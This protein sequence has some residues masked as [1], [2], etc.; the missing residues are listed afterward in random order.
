MS[1]AWRSLL[2]RLIETAERRDAAPSLVSPTETLSY[3]Q[4][5]D[6]ALEL[7]ARLAPARGELVA[8]ALP[9][10][11]GLVTAWLACW[12]AGAAFSTLDPSLPEARARDILR[13]LAPRFVL[14]ASG[15]AKCGAHAGEELWIDTAASASNPVEGVWS[16]ARALPM[17][18]PDALA[19]VC[20]TSGST[21][22]PKGAT[23]EH[24][25]LPHVIGDQVRAFE[26]DESAR[27]L[28]LLRPGFDASL[29]DV[30]TCLLAGGELHLAPGLDAGFTTE[31]LLESLKG[32]QITHVDLP[33][34]LLPRIPVEKLPESLR[35]VVVGGEAPDPTA[36]SD[37]AR[38]VRLLNV[39][40]P[41]ECSIC[42]SLLAWE[43][44]FARPYIGE[45]LSAV[46][47]RIGPADAARGEL[48]I[49]GAQLMRGY[50]EAPE[51][52][53][54]RFTELNGVRWYRTG[55]LVERTRRGPVFLGRTD[56]QLKLRGQLIAPEEVEA[57]L[58]GSG[59]CERAHVT[60]HGERLVALIQGDAKQESRL[61][62]TLRERLP[63]WMHPAR[64]VFYRHLPETASGK[65]DGA[66]LL[67]A[68]DAE[69]AT[70]ASDAP[71]TLLEVVA[72]RLGRADPQLSYF[73]QGGDSL[74]VLEVLCE[75]EAL[76]LEIT[77]EALAS[78][79][80]LGDL[81][82]AGE[83]ATTTP[84]DALDRD[85]RACL[86][87]IRPVSPQGS[88]LREVTLMT[89]AT[90]FLGSKTLLDLLEIEA[91]QHYVALVRARDAAHARRR[92]EAACDA[93]SP[94]SFRRLGE[95]RVRCLVGDVALPDLGL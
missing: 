85:A 66:A 17:P 84:A 40:G 9:K 18:A 6:A 49:A 87:R 58:L 25:G 41:T 43:P 90:G 57:V 32:R 83:M 23:L 12:L 1:A 22:S 46:K 52:D 91:E 33:P 11:H 79:R 88:N 70:R 21:G 68:L 4:L 69:A 73:A 37:W 27:C 35:C 31:K 13:R 61:L 28:W 77:P 15:G 34:S 86:A 81:E 44:D 95:G 3:A 55:D 24:R 92:L 14:R 72:R 29:S 53:A 89:G 59:A 74:G 56:R 65:L 93:H 26:L 38:R 20:W 62:T 5:F 75:C 71:R 50:F 19:Y 63:R 80:P 2:E 36:A 78:E 54:E 94:G 8:L 42:T 45:P 48:W 47:Y 7:S 51:L 82:S 39:Y 76:G 16:R 64:F 67:A 60:L 30:F 10:S